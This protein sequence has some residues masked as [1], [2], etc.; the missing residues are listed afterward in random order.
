LV[1]TLSKLR[2]IGALD[3]DMCGDGGE[4]RKFV[5]SMVSIDIFS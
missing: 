5:S 3:E 2:I 4:S 1:A